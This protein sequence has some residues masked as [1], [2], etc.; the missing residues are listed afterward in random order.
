MTSSHEVKPSNLPAD[1]SYGIKLLAEAGQKGWISPAQLAGAIEFVRETIAV[2][3][4]RGEISGQ[5]E[6][7]QN[8]KTIG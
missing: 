3:T 2:R 5:M 1:M 4:A 7:G 6:G 8:K